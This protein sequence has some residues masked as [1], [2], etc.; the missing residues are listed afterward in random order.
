[1]NRILENKDIKQYMLCLVENKNT[2][3]DQDVEPLT[4]NV[5]LRIANNPA[6]SIYKY[7]QQINDDH[8][9]QDDKKISIENLK[10][11]ILKLENLGLIKKVIEKNKTDKISVKNNVVEEIYYS[12]T[13]L[14]LFY[15]LNKN[16]INSIKNIVLKN[17][18]DVFFETFLYPYIE[19]ETI[20]KLKGNDILSALSKYLVTCAK[21]INNV[22]IDHLLKIQDDD[23]NK[24]MVGFPR[25]LY[26]PESKDLYEFGSISIYTIFEK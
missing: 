24:I 21:I 1:M 22:M 16:I 25:S 11:I 18:K 2:L 3:I 5:L 7:H 4:D 26:V 13:S 23:G 10:I 20:E 15:L 17:R 8:L 14:G 12:V 6:K 19:F 9:K